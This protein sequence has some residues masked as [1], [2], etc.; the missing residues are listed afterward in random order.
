MT[1]R[2]PATILALL[3]A[4]LIGLSSRAPSTTAQPLPAL[5]QHS[6]VPLVTSSGHA[7]TPEPTATAT[8]QP[9]APVTPQPTATATPEPTAPPVDEAAYTAEV[10]R[11]I[12]DDRVSHGCPATVPNDMLATGAQTW[13]QYMVDTLTYQH[14]PMG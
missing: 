6:V 7:V 1:S 13:T 5:T 4:L 11:V 2:S 3:A 12:N 14:A 9:T 8:P 10:I